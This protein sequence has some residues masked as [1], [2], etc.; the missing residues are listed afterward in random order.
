M[1]KINHELQTKLS[2]LLTAM[3]YDLLG[4]ELIP[5][6][7]STVFR[8]YIDS[9]GG[10]TVDD[11]SK[12]SHQVSAML[13]AEDPINGRYNLEVSSPGLDRPLF[14]LDQFLKF[15]GSRIKIKL[16]RSIGNRRQFK[17]I[18]Q[19]IENDTIYLL[20]EGEEEPV[21][22]PFTEIDKANVIGDVRW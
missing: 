16:S 1:R 17:G 9:P 13:D 6:R 2:T 4:V 19:R 22:I 11:C 5:Q 10:V 15:I 12:V 21:Q 3:G 14:E 7:G 20:V 8:L 18:L